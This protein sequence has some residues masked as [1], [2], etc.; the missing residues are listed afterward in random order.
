MRV[1]QFRPGR[2]L[3]LAILNE[4]FRAKSG[5]TAFNFLERNNS[6]FPSSN[7]ILRNLQWN[8][9]SVWRNSHAILHWNAVVIVLVGPED[10]G[11]RHHRSSN[12]ETEETMTQMY[13]L[14]GAE[15]DAV[16]AGAL[17]EVNN[18]NIAVPVNAAAAVA[19]LSAGTTAIAEQDARIVQ[20]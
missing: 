4:R 20:V 12:Q 18:N 7:T 14:T 8:I 13:E 19:V 11:K 10:D 15:L 16:A 17:V 9:P 6:K 3:N 2:I 1:R 5:K